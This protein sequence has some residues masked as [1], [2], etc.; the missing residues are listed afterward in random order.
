MHT[1][2]VQLS[3]LARRHIKLDQLDEFHCIMPKDIPKPKPP[4]KPPV[5]PAATPPTA[6]SAA[7]SQ[8]QAATSQTRDAASQLQDPAIQPEDAASHTTSAAS[9]PLDAASPPQEPAATSHHASSSNTSSSSS[10]LQDTQSS[11]PSIGLDETQAPV[12]SNG[13]SVPKTAD[14]VVPRTVTSTEAGVPAEQQ[15][16]HTVQ[17]TPSVDEAGKDEEQALSGSVNKSGFEFSGSG[18]QF[19]VGAPFTE[20][21]TGQERTYTESLIV[22]YLESKMAQL[23]KHCMA[24]VMS[25]LYALICNLQC[26]QL[27]MARIQTVAISCHM[28]SKSRRHGLL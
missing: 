23:S 13:A 15:P 25:I 21:M 6:P 10:N 11:S 22:W 20:I 27:L 1:L 7:A 2:F 17:A 16:Q 4:S 3:S 19:K 5:D 8:P 26:W 14:G 24:P 9:Q 18:E 28:F 12:G